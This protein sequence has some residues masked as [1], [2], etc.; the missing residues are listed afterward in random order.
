MSDSNMP[1]NVWSLHHI[2]TVDCNTKEHFTLAK[3]ERT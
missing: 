3:Y 2:H 1:Q